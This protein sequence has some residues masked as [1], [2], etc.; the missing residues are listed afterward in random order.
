MPQSIPPTHLEGESRLRVLGLYGD[1][2]RNHRRTTSFP[3]LP[4]GAI[5]NVNIDSPPWEGETKED[6]VA[7]VN[8]NINRA[9]HRATEAALVLAVA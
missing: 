1:Y 9:Q 5:F 7:R 6:R 8:R 2:R 4:W 3:S